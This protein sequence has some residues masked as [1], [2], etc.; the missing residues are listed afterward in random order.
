M[1]FVLC[2][3]QGCLYLWDV[4]KGEVLRIVDLGSRHDSCVSIRQLHVIDNC[5]V[6]DFGNQLR[7]IKFPSVLE[8]AD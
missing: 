3:L 7:V 6:C 1:T 2:S 5:V 4:V 8:K